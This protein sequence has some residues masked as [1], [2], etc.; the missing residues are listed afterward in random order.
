MAAN[1]RYSGNHRWPA[2]AGSLLGLATASLTAM[3]AMPLSAAERQLGT[4]GELTAWMAEGQKC[5]NQLSVTLRAKDPTVFSGDLTELQK[6]ISLIAPTLQAGC[7]RM[8]TIRL[9]ARI[10]DREVTRGTAQATANWIATLRPVRLPKETNRQNARTG[11]DRPN[12]TEPAPAPLQ[13]VD[14]EPPAGRWKGETACGPARNKTEILV[15]FG[16]AEDGRHRGLIS[17]LP[18]MRDLGVRETGAL[19]A[20]Y[21]DTIN[22]FRVAAMSTEHPRMVR[23]IPY[24]FTME[25]RSYD[26]IGGEFLS[27]TCQ[28]FTLLRDKTYQ[29]RMTPG[30]TMPEGDASMAKAETPRQRCE[31]LYRWVQKSTNEMTAARRQQNYH[32]DHYLLFGDHDFIPV[33]G[34]AYDQATPSLLEAAH[35]T[36]RE[37]NQ[38]PLGQQR[39]QNFGTL[40]SPLRSRQIPKASAVDTIL[41]RQREVHHLVQQASDHG[42]L[43][44]AALGKAVEEARRA[45]DSARQSLWP[46]DYARLNE[47]LDAAS[48]KAATAAAERR[49]ADLRAINDPNEFLLAARNAL[50]TRKTWMAGTNDARQAAWTEEIS[51]RRASVAASLAAPIMALIDDQ[52][53]TIDG[54]LAA[55]RL[56]GDHKHQLA[57][58]DQEVLVSAQAGWTERQHTRI[59]NLVQPELNSL[60]QLPR[61]RSGLETSKS[62]YDSFEARFAALATMPEVA[63]VKTQFSQY[64]STLLQELLPDLEQELAQSSSD[65][66]SAGMHRLQLVSRYLNW[67]GDLRLPISMEYLLIARENTQP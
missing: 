45:L 63:V 33:F 55:N 47:T 19:T 38:D 48:Q 14:G 17:L 36:W 20:E 59:Q 7:P 2:T 30:I 27:R 56:V 40:Q 37:C 61:D 44:S 16:L 65:T 11:N 22:K 43:D 62:W 52:P 13:I 42:G 8:R 57:R 9:S 23:P 60:A 34:V 5:T 1:R 10:N 35:N 21:D 31:A 58:M 32:H 51:E 54:L 39:L 24:G 3:I 66:R 29:I 64:R 53:P 6:L 50:D 15:S 18:V 41:H 26:E 28:P 4:V 12:N 46:T 49:M 67:P 25:A